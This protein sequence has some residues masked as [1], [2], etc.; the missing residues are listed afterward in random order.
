MPV[1]SEQQVLNAPGSPLATGTPLGNA[2]AALVL[3]AAPGYTAGALLAGLIAFT[4]YGWVAFHP[5]PP[6]T[7]TPEQDTPEEQSDPQPQVV[8]PPPPQP[9][10]PTI[11]GFVI[12]QPVPQPEN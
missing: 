12:G 6:E 10:V 9:G 2:F 5:T 8:Q 1:E 3:L 7:R 4:G 11:P